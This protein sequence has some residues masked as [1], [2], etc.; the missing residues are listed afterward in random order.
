ML[1]LIDLFAPIGFGHDVA[2]PKAGKPRFEKK[3][4]SLK[5]NIRMCIP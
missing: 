5:R 3:F 2:A 1:R 4:L